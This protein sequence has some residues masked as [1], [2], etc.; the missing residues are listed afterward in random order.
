MN[1]VA[2]YDIKQGNLLHINVEVEA[3]T[4]PNISIAFA[5][6]REDISMYV[7]C[8]TE[9]TV[10]SLKLRIGDN[11]PNVPPPC[12]QQLVCN[13]LRMEDNEWL[14]KFKIFEHPI[15]LNEEF[16]VHLIVR[17]PTNNTINIHISSE[18][19]LFNL[20]CLIRDRTSPPIKVSKQQ[21]YYQG[22]VLEDT[23]TISSCNFPSDPLLQLCELVQCVLLC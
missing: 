12:R 20:K 21:L 4:C 22:R 3:D 15:V 2:D 8:I 6:G 13:G 1:N 16:R 19:N 14:V 10:L 23:H 11:V 9:C 18:K 17:T 5:N 7:P